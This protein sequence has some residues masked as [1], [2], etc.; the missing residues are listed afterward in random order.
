M[1]EV[2][3]Q[4]S[5]TTDDDKAFARAI[6]LSMDAVRAAR[7]VMGLERSLKSIL[8]IDPIAMRISNIRPNGAKESRID[9]T[10]TEGQV[11][12]LSSF[13]DQ[14]GERETVF[15]ETCALVEE[16]V[17]GQRLSDNA[18]REIKHILTEK[19]FIE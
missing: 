13:L 15:K 6:G 5:D 8:S 17:D 9:F 11:E 10:L 19:G 3:F 18:I 4:M 7:K 12:T 14:N 2:N 16:W 1:N